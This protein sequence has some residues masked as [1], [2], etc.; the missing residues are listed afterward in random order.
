[1]YRT[2]L[3]G[4]FLCAMM[5]VNSSAADSGARDERAFVRALEKF[6]AAKSPADYRES[7]NILES[8]LSD[9]YRSGAVYYNLGNA[10]FRAGDF[11]R[12]TLN[13]RKAK[14]YRPRD[15]YLNANLEQALAAAPGRLAEPA[16][17][18]WTHVLFWTEW[19]AYP[20][21]VYLFFIASTLAAIGTSL[22]VILRQ[23]R[24]YPV[25]AGLFFISI[26]IGVDAAI[27]EA[28]V[29]RSD[30]AVV[31]AETIARKGTG[32]S[33]EPVFDRPLR[34]C[35]VSYFENDI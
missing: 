31:T 7:A 30:R 20:T 1:M 5:T 10:Y 34:G 12:A 2:F 14:P 33:Y 13:Y 17:P 15:P 16:R 25:A 8:M 3:V 4:L 18:W 28:D 32:N 35:R 9:G 23:R 22:A 11:G 6:D 24:M 21:K 26:A 19:L 29:V 27:C